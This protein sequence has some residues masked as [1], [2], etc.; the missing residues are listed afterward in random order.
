MTKSVSIP[1]E[2]EWLNISRLVQGL[3][4]LVPR[5]GVEGSGRNG[6]RAALAALRRGLGKE[7]GEAPEVFPVLMPLLPEAPLWPWPERVAYLIAS[8]FAL[9]PLSWSKASR[10]RHRSNLGASMRQLAG[11]AGEAESNGPERR[12]VALLNSDVADLPD[13]L[14]GI[15]G[16]LKSADP[17][18]PVDWAQLA[19]DLLYWSDA[20]REVQRRWATAFW[21]GRWTDE[22]TDKLASDETE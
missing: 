7:P 19:R 14:R 17:P 13:H 4:R 20:D 1:A 18:I 10:G 16:L 21:G 5:D 22:T 6:D 12:F 8:L 3:E 11:E 15:V 9:H 2:R